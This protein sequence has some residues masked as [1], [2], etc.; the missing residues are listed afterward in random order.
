MCIRDRHKEYLNSVLEALYFGDKNAK[1][2]EIIVQVMDIAFEFHSL[3]QKFENLKPNDDFY[4]EAVGISK[5]LEDLQGSFLTS[6]RLLLPALRTGYQR[7][8]P[9]KNLSWMFPNLNFN[10]YYMS[11]QGEIKF[12]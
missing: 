5:D 12:E 10:N 3:V 7:S 1:K 2:Q 8:G 11:H 6:M 4:T 9:A